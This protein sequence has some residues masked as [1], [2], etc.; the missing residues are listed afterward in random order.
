[1]APLSNA[2]SFGTTFVPRLNIQFVCFTEFQ[3]CI[4]FFQL[5]NTF[6]Y[7]FTC[8]IGPSVE[9]R[10]RNKEKKRDKTKKFSRRRRSCS[11]NM[12]LQLDGG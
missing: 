2:L 10:Q 9:K 5:V 8:K 4:F 7:H 12:Y 6:H 11:V 1:M 3:D